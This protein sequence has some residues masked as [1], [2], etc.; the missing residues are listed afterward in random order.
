MKPL[1]I[2]LLADMHYYSRI[3]AFYLATIGTRNC[4]LKVNYSVLLANIAIYLLSLKS[5]EDSVI[6][7]GLL[8]I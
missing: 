8:D 2:C 1:S 6:L 4:N 3:T 5:L 7:H